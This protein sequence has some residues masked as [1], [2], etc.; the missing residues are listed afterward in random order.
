MPAYSFVERFCPWV[1]E[2]SKTQ[3]VRAPRKGRQ[4][5]A[6]PG[7]TVYLYFGMRTKFCKKL[8]EGVCT[9]RKE[10][11]ITSDSI[12]I[13]GRG[14]SHDEMHLFAWKDGF[15]PEGTTEEEPW[16]AWTAMRRFWKETHGLDAEHPWKGIVIYWQLKPKSEWKTV[17]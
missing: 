13:D 11:T 15:R 12:Y 2:G 8:G 7:D 6:K 9:E 14:L 3:T 10:I 17:K 5:H 16:G 1:I 4:G